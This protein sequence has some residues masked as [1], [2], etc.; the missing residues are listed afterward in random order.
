MEMMI[1][2][3]IQKDNKINFEEVNDKFKHKDIFNKKINT[4]ILNE[5]NRK[6]DNL[7]YYESIINDSISG[8]GLRPGPA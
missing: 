4:E 1:A 3:L 2:K 8:H 6:N 7:T 5:S